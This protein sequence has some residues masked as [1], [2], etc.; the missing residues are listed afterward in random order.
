MLELFENNIDI[1]ETNI[2]D[3]NQYDQTCME[4]L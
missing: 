4:V 2:L 3:T 1:L